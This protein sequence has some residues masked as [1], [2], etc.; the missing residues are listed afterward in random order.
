M[1]GQEPGLSL[2]KSSIPFVA[3]IAVAVMIGGWLHVDIVRNDLQTQINEL[4]RMQ[5]KIVRMMQGDAVE[6]EVEMMEDV[7]AK[8]YSSLIHQGD[9]GSFQLLTS[10]AC[11]RK[12]VTEP[13]ESGRNFISEFELFLLEKVDTPAG[14]RDQLGHFGI[15]TSED[16]AD[17][18]SDE[19]PG[20]PTVLQVL[21]NGLLLVK[22]GPQDL[23]SEESFMAPTGERCDYEIRYY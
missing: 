21:S 6:E 18:P 19:F 3:M 15:L 1:E 23:P 7:D 13:I 17:I 16:Y 2:P 8:G 4:S 9:V 11:Q 22:Y 10:E 12:Y 5:P 14:R 20:K